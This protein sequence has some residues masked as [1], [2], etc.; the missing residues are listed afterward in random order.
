M[1]FEFLTEE[2]KR[3]LRS[4]SS[5]G[6]FDSEDKKCKR[7]SMVAPCKFDAKFIQDRKLSRMC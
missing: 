3:D 2:N 5:Y 1:K 4:C 6:S 7:C